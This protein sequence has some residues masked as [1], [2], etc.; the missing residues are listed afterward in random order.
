MTRKQALHKALQ[1]VTDKEVIAKINEIIGDMPFT[2]WSEQTIFDTIDQF[3]IDNGRMPAA[4]DF[5]KKGLPPHPVIKLR[6]GMN[7]K[8][9]L[10]KYYPTERL[11]GSRVYFNKSKEDWRDLF[12]A[13]YTKKKPH[14]AEEYN[15]VREAQLPTWGTLAK[16]FYVDKWLDWLAF[17]GVEKY[18]ADGYK[19]KKRVKLVVSSHTDLD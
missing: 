19:Q 3:I 14:S 2:G 12:I 17:C 8:E 6:F 1:A 7:L 13:D 18:Y 9:F 11:C 5:R 15:S 16:M 10:L 4:T